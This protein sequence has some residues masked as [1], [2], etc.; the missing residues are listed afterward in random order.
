MNLKVTHQLQAFSNAIR[1]TFMQHFIRF[2]LTVCSHG[3]S[4][5]AELLVY[6]G[7]AYT[8]TG[9]TGYHLAQEAWQ[10]SLDKQIMVRSRYVSYKLCALEPRGAQ[11]HEQLPSI[12]L[13]CT[14]TLLSSTVS[15]SQ[16]QSMYSDHLLTTNSDP[17]VIE[18]RQT[19][20]MF[21]L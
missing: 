13:Q 10:Y 15:D 17:G 12:R 21:L 6:S 16:S 20:R 4:A 7:A 19:T 2:Q 9:I 11:W 8:L 18:P 14:G 3:S 1:R 5:L